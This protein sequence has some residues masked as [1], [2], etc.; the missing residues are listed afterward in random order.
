MKKVITVLVFSI[1]FSFTQTLKASEETH[2]KVAEEFINMMDVK[3]M[4]NHGFEQVKQ[5]FMSQ[6]DPM[7]TNME[8]TTKAQLIREKIAAKLNKELS[9]ETLKS[10]YI[11]L[12]TEIFTEEEMQGILDFYKGPMG[13][14][15]ME[16][17]PELMG[18]S[19]QI[20]ERKVNEIMPEI[21]N[22]IKETGGGRQDQYKNEIPKDQ[23]QMQ[24]NRH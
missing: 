14:K 18:R 15:L 2:N 16:K 6:I 13:Q 21:G 3:N 24:M 22:M 12:Y 17:T 5:V 10:E 19:V 7:F 1:V 20:G 4:E 11:K 23:I 9:W 8:D